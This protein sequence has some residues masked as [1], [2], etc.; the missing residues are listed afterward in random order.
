MFLYVL[1]FI[2]YIRCLVLTRQ[3]FYVYHNFIFF[4]LIFHLKKDECSF[5]KYHNLNFFDLIFILNKTNA[6]FLRVKVEPNIPELKLDISPIL[7]VWYKYAYFV[8]PHTNF[9]KCKILKNTSTKILNVWTICEWT[10]SRSSEEFG[11]HLNFD[12]KPQ[13]E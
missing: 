10:I 13:C 2:I 4:D 7:I 1:N 9:I 8:G 6:N 3:T 5:Y 12:F 11:Y